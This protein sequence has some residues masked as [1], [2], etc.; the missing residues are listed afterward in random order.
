METNG[1]SELVFIDSDIYP[2]PNGIL[3]MNLAGKYTGRR[4]G[5]YGAREL[6]YNELHREY[7]FIVYDFD[8][9]ANHII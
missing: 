6:K 1:K 9:Y 7:I 3:A 8:Y 2:N 4:G 5:W